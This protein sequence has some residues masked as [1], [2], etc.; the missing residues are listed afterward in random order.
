MSANLSV[1]NYGTSD[2]YSAF[3]MRKTHEGADHGFEPRFMPSQVKDFQESMICFAQRKGRA[4]IFED[5]GM[6]KTLQFLT[7]GQ[8]VAMHENK[9][10]LILTPLAVAGQT[11]REGAKFDIPVVRSRAGEMPSGDLIV[12]NYQQLHKLDPS[13]F[14]GVIC[15][16]SSI[17]KNFD[18]S[19]RAEV[20]QFMRKVPFRLLASATAAPNDYVELGTSSEALGYLGHMDMLARFFKN[21]QNNCSV[22]RM[23]GEAAKWRFKGH[24]ETPFWRWVCSWAR[25]MRRPSDLGFDDGGFVLPPMDEHE[26]LVESSFRANGMLYE[27][28][29]V[30]LP[31]QREELKATVKE[32]CAKV[33]ELLDHDHPAIAWCHLDAEGD[34]LERII[35]GAV[36]I[37]GKQSD[38]VKEERFMA[39][40][41]GQIRCLV[42]KPK[43]GAW[44]LNFQ[45]CA[46]VAYFPSH[47]FEQKY[48]AVRRCYRFG[49][50]RTVRV[51]VVHTEGQRKVLENQNR[52][53]RQAEE[54]FS[55]LVREMNHAIGIERINDHTT[56]MEVPS[57]L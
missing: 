51:D 12:T 54:M 18:G 56:R 7:W 45:H 42:T 22:G 57:W 27:L 37:S 5:C 24:A 49:Q 31:E 1:D 15:D 19:T 2:A 35:P 28:P 41:D 17:L 21:E 26:H 43:I 33:A 39:F 6:G 14:G 4:A 9:P 36:Q 46:H 50:S 34:E 29:A 52:K 47:S 3:L 8:N 48:Q 16:E 10:V 32:R 23:Y 53:Q 20:T 13:K 40:L 11:V 55:A 25:A 44:G 30:T 38:A